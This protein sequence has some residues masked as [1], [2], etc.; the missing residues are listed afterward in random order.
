MRKLLQM[1]S[2]SRGV[3]G[4]DFFGGGGLGGAK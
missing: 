2:E 3:N 4:L 1:Q